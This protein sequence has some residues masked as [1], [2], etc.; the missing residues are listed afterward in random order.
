MH[1]CACTY[2]NFYTYLQY[3][4]GLDIACTFEAHEAPRREYKIHV[5]DLKTLTARL[6]SPHT[7]KGL[8][9]LY[10]RMPTLLYAYSSFCMETHIMH[11]VLLLV[12]LIE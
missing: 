5:L 10:L 2:S 3:V 9:F 6:S 1:A 11:L 12:C 4:T 8:R 7:G